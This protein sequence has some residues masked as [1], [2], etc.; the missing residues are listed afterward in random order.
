M[1]AVLIAWSKKAYVNVSI[2]VPSHTITHNIL[3]GQA[4]GA[5][6]SQMIRIYC[7][8]PFCLLM[9]APLDFTC[10]AV[11][12]GECECTAMVGG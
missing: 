9:N 6:G 1:Q 3:K 8:S 10:A 12:F 4:L 11:Q 7:M 2:S 5:H